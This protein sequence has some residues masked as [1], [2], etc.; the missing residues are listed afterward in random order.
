MAKKLTTAPTFYQGVLHPAGTMLDIDDEAGDFVFSGK[1][2]NTPNLT[3]AKNF[4]APAYVEVAPIA[5]SGPNPTAP[6]Q[7]PPG[8]MQTASGFVS[9]DGSRLVPEGAET[10]AEVEE[11]KPA[12]RS[13][14][15]ASDEA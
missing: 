11:E 8:T 2:A 7:V 1:D 6:Q 3:D 12:R 15:K 14:K 9:S 13:T 5:P 10:P 4:E